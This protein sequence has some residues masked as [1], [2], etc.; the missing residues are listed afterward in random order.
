MIEVNMRIR[1]LSRN[2]FKLAEAKAILEPAGIEVV[3]LR[4]EIE[5]LQTP[6]IER[7]VQDK[8]LQAFKVVGRPVF[9]EHTGLYIDSM[10]GLPGGLTQVFW[11]KLEA[12]RFAEFFGTRPINTV[13]A[14]TVVGY[15]DGKKV[16]MFSGSIRG[17]IPAEPRGSRLFQWDCV[18]Q[19]DGEDQ[20]FAEMGDRKNEMSMRRRALD[21]FAEFLKEQRRA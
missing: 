12:D 19:P 10:S 1:F 4:K 8:C 5:E 13:E 20:T 16:H 7:I 17:T 9:V 14:R 21:Q 3:P 11:D 2:Q 6:D 15:C 18:F